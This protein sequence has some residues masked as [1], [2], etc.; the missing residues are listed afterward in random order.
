MAG[1]VA[2]FSSS[3]HG[4]TIVFRPPAGTWSCTI[5]PP[6]RVMVTSAGDWFGLATATAKW[7]SAMSS[8]LAVTVG[9]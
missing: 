8:V 5:M 2:F 7:A 1:A 3:T 9:Q 6:G 4:S